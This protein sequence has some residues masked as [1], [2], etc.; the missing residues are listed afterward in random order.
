[1]FTSLPASSSM[2]SIRR[3][4]LAAPAR[5]A[6]AA[7]RARRRCR[8]RARRVVG[9][10]QVLVAALARRDAP[11]PRSCCGRRRPPCG[12]AGRRGCPPR[13]DQS[14]QPVPRPSSRARLELA[15]ILA[16][17]RLDVGEPERAH[18]APP[19]SAHVRVRPIASSSTPYSDTCSPRRTAA[20]RSAALCAPEPVKCCS[21]LPSWLGLAI[22]RSTAH[23]RVGAPPRAGSARRAD[24]LDLAQPRRALR[25][26]RRAGRDRDQV[27]V[28]DA[29]GASGAPSPP[30]AP[31]VPGLALRRVRPATSASPSFDR[32]AAA[33]CAAPRAR[34]RRRPA[35]PARLPRA[36]APAHAPSAGA[37][38]APPRAASA[39]ES[40]PSSEC[41]SRARLGPRPGQARDRD[42][43]R[44]KLRTQLLRRWNRARFSSARIFSCSV[45]P[46]AGSS[47]ARPARA[48]A[49]TDTD[50][51]RTVLAAAR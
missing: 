44:R 15:A 42:Q 18:T 13:L 37:R 28:L 19:R 30:A 51:S 39:S 9:D 1:M 24:A 32:P 41:S 20:S 14:R 10:R 48:S 5:S 36:S 3:V 8:S 25:Q 46:I 6:G 35:T 22:R 49:A 34:R 2:P 7:A 40:M 4:H 23:A 29:V 45:L 50:A 12:C 11:S 21:R 33:A 26:R 43:P 27:E 38:A 16:Q 47:V 31:A 17:L